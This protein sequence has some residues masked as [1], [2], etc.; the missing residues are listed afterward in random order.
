M[1]NCILR[2]CLF[3]ELHHITSGIMGQFPYSRSHYKLSHFMPDYVRDK[4]KS[5][6]LGPLLERSYEEYYQH[7]SS[8][9]VEVVRSKYIVLYEQERLCGLHIYHAKVFKNLFCLLSWYGRTG[10]VHTCR[11]LRWGQ[12]RPSNQFPLTSKWWSQLEQES[13]SS[14][15]DQRLANACTPGPPS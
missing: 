8:K 7:F 2:K 11:A 6:P 15:G 1:Y 12:M 13:S 14:T 10:S 9:P 3:K 4:V 5:D